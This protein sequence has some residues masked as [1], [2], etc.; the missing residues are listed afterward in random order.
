MEQLRTDLSR[1]RRRLFWHELLRVLPRFW[2]VALSVAAAAVLTDRFFPLGVEPAGWIGGAL[3]LGTALA[4]CWT[5]IGQRT[6]LDAATEVDRRFQLQDTVATA[7]S[8]S[9]DELR[10]PA[11]R[12]VL[13]DATRRLNQIEVGQKFCVRPDRWCW[14]PLLP[15][16]ALVGVL[17]AFPMAAETTAATAKRQ[18]DETRRQVQASAR[19]LQRRMAERRVKAKQE[20]LRTAEELLNRIE[21]ATERELA[22]KPPAQRQQALVKLNDLSKEIAERRRQLAGSEQM[23]KQLDALKDLGSG[24]ADK[25]A[26]ALREGNL[27]AAME[28]LRKLAKQVENGELGAEQ[29]EQLAQ[30]LDKMRQQLAEQAAAQQDAEQKLEQQLAA[31][32]A[33]GNKADAA[34]L[35]EKLE[36]LRQHNGAKGLEQ[37][38]AQRMEQAA[39]CLREGRAQDAEAAMAAMGEELAQMQGD[40]AEAELLDAALDEL[41][42]AK[43][44]MGCKHCQGQGCGQCRGHGARAHDMA[45]RDGG[46]RGGREWGT[47]H[48]DNPPPQEGIETQTYDSKV[49]Q[50]VG[51]GAASVVD[52]VDGPQAKGRVTEEIE[53]Q[54]ADA[55]AEASDPLTGQRLP[56]AT[57]SHARQYF[58]ALREGG[59]AS[60]AHD[61]VGAAPADAADEAA[62]TDE[63]AEPATAEPQ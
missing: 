12:A 19:E 42:D 54:F 56:R 10:S 28:Q 7:L 17:I 39:K 55:Q 20:G 11:G 1:A 60:P 49:A 34:K 4:L 36:Q 21:R 6:A 44:S 43:Q 47:G 18:Q 9:P 63:G 58:E 41:A 16:L 50:R 8:L 40:M 25:F 30:Q 3:V 37:K 13:A 23:Q 27:N 29:R 59:T 52:L 22:A 24:P 31:A 15:A 48:V 51:Q 53:S 32:E 61:D 62:E 5:L 35:A 45:R 57:Q 46:G 14:L 38:L 2:A 33:A 26:E